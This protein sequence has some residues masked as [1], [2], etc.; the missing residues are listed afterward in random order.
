VRRI[1]PAL[2]VVVVTVVLAAVMLLT[3]EGVAHVAHSAIAALGVAANLHFMNTTGGYFDQAS[4]D[5]PLL[6]TWSLSVEEQ[7]YFVWPLLLLMRRKWLLPALTVASL[8]LAEWL[9]HADP[10]AAFYQMP[11]R[12]WELGAGALVATAQPRSVRWLASVG[13]TMLAA[14]IVVPLPTFPGVG[15][16]PAVLGA[17]AVI[18]AVHSGASV[19]LLETRPVRFVGMISYSLYLW[20]W[21]VLVFWRLTHLD[22]PSV[23]VSLALC[24][25]SGVLAFVSYRLIE[26]PFRRIRQPAGRVVGGGVAACIVGVVMVGTMIHPATASAPALDAALF[27]PAKVAPSMA[28]WGDSHAG[29]WAPIIAE[30]AHRE[31]RGMLD[32]STPSCP[33]LLGVMPVDAGCIQ[34]NAATVKRLQGFDTVLIGARWIPLFSAM[35][36]GFQG[37]YPDDAA[38]IARMTEGV[39]RAVA[40]LSSVRRII[41][42]GP[43]PQLRAT[44]ERCLASGAPDRCAMTRAQFDQLA[45]RPRRFL[46]ALAAKYPNVEVIDPADF[47]CT[48]KA[49][50]VIAHGI[51]LYRDDDHIST[52]AARAF[53]RQAAN[54]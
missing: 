19:P 14:A 47:L 42:V 2:I 41:L 12:A 39:E 31:G 4:A 32:A 9:R 38:S 51:T 27:V 52:D 15:A 17:A 22:A 6:H 11:A 29:M 23:P 54:P 8:L 20:H 48:P 44:A 16:L 7:F 35:P 49:C 36:D 21:P 28:V 50:P 10:Q 53:A 40:S 37:I 46:A 43:V 25:A 18:Y 13:L 3:P 45:D 24:L 30:R 5:M 33:P 1:L 26:E 34:H